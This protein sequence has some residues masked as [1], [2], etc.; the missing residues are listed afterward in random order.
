MTDANP[1]PHESI[2]IDLKSL[3]NSGSHLIGL[4]EPTWI[5]KKI[6]F[7]RLGNDDCTIY[8]KLYPDDQQDN[9][10]GIVIKVYPT[11]SDV[12]TDHQKAFRL[13]EQLVHQRIAPRILLTF[14]NGYFSTYILGKT[15]NVNEDHT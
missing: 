5:S 7:K 8:Y 14:I 4:I 3:E 13:I 12:Y 11:N 10:H 9:Q 2:V 6:I 15:L 1:I